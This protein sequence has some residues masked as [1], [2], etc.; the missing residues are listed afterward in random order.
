MQVL[1]VMQCKKLAVMCAFLCSLLCTAWSPAEANCSIDAMTANLQV[2]SDVPLGG[3]ASKFV[4]ESPDQN[5]W[6]NQLKPVP[7]SIADL[8]T[9]GFEIRTSSSQGGAD[10]K[11]RNIDSNVLQLGRIAVVCTYEYDLDGLDKVKYSRANCAQFV[12]YR[13][14]TK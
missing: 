5:R 7:C 14:L 6:L 11:A 1:N 13:L 4:A 9:L 3:E 12:P 2:P 10:T 8:L